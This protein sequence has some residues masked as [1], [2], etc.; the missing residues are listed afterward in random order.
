VLSTN[1]TFETLYALFPEAGDRPEATVIPAE[2]VPQPYRRLLVHNHHM[3]VTVEDYHGGPVDVKVL[4]CRRNEDEYA[5]KILLALHE[6]GRIVQFGLVRI[7]LGVCPEPVRNE[8]LEGQTPL[9]RILIEH[10]MLRRIEPTAFVKVKLSSKMAEWFGS[11]AGAATYGRLGV[12]YT[13]DRPAVEVL[14]ILAP[15]N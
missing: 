2:D 13:G 1:P 8:I 4:A 15:I 12:I 6:G 7:D 9:G 10:D 5:R 11:T 3:T 14:E